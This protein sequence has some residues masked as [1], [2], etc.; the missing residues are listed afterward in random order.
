MEEPPTTYMY[1][2]MK[3]LNAI[4]GFNISIYTNVLISTNTSDNCYTYFI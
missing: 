3:F 4:V 2:G 1:I